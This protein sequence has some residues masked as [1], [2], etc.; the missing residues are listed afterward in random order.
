MDVKRFNKCIEDINIAINEIKKMKLYPQNIIAEL[1][2]IPSHNHQAFYVILN[3]S[4]NE[5][6]LTYIKPNI[7][8]N[9]NQESIKMYSFETCKRAETHPVTDGRFVIGIK[10]ISA[11][12]IYRFQTLFLN[13]PD[14]YLFEDKGIYIDGVLQ[15][16][17]LFGE[18]PK[19]VFYHDANQINGLSREQA[20]FFDNL[21]LE[22]EKIIDS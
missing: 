2:C 17:R 7:Y 8:L 6:Q 14:K 3:K 20:D 21:Y 1:Y 18:N 12:T 15:G 22:I 16:I 5:F 19:E 10:K 11:N 13:L 9:G 4:N